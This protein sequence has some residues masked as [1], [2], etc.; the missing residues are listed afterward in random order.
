M[1]QVKEGRAYLGICATL[2]LWGLNYWIGR[3]L[4]SPVLFG[5]VHMP[6]LVYG[7]ARYG[8][9][10]LTLWTILGL[11]RSADRNRLAGLSQHRAAFF[12]STVSS[13]VFVVCAHASHAYVSSATT[14]VIVNLCPVIVLVYGVIF[15]QE[16][17][18][19]TRILG[20]GLGLAAGLIFLTLS[21]GGGHGGSRNPGV[22]LSL[23]A[24]LG[25]AGYTIGLSYLGGLD[26]AMVLAVQQTAA[27]LMVLPFMLVYGSAAP[28]FIVPDLWSVFLL[29]FAGILGSGVAYIFYFEA[30]RS[31]GA[32]RVASFLTMIPAVALF[33]DALLGD[34]PPAPAIAA[35]V[36]AILGIVLI[37]RS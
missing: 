17:P 5:Y 22:T 15:L 10:A 16:K 7:F 3:V 26:R 9:G 35:A 31:L 27:T 2:V 37:K 36:L 18:S 33:A 29:A 20:F 32:S 28:L 25:W 21:W 23:L 8:I 34:L 11:S 6:G 14:A 19:R 1:D 13:A 24:M 30:I 12:W 4:A